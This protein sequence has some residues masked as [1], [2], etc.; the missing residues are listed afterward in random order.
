MYSEFY[1]AIKARVPEAAVH[2]IMSD[3]GNNITSVTSIATY[4]YLRSYT[5][6]IYIYIYIYI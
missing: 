6:N 4:T 2:T 5:Y 3:D 1:K